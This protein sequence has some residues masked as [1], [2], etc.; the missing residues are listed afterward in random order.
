MCV[1]VQMK[2][3]VEVCDSLGYYNVKGKWKYAQ[4]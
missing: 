1:G 4:F 3:D 2:G